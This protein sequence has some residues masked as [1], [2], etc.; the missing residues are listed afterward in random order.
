[1]TA[2]PHVGAPNRQ[3]RQL[4]TIL[5][6]TPP[7][8]QLQVAQSPGSRLDGVRSRFVVQEAHDAPSPEDKILVLSRVCNGVTRHAC[9][10]R[11][12]LKSG[13]C[14]ALRSNMARADIMASGWVAG[15]RKPRFVSV[16]QVQSTHPSWCW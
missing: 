15:G 7:S 11:T 4:S 2:V 8:W 6:I 3:R 13:P 9:Y 10:R 14:P 1:M 16:P 12:E 5:H